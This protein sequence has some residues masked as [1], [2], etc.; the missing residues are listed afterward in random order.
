MHKDRIAEWLLESVTTREGAATTVGDLREIAATRGEAW[1]WRS[2][3]TT[4]TSLLW[5]EVAD[6]PRRMLS[7]ALRGWLV[8]V[9]YGLL[10]VLLT[11]FLVGVLAGAL[12]LRGNNAA[13]PG[14]FLAPIGEGLFLLTQF[15]TGRWI[16]RRAPGSELPACLAFALL[17]ALLAAI[18]IF[19]PVVGFQ[20]DARVHHTLDSTWF[21]LTYPFCFLGALTV[22]R[23]R[24]RT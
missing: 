22:R 9:G 5:Q 12:T 2:V 14:A 6:H 1:F 17:Q 4:S 10:A 3:L 20:S 7:L 15:L 23:R 8:S 19:G 18:A 16:A 13:I 24:V 11:V 21:F